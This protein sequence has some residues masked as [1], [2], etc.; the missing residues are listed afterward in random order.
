[1]RLWTKCDRCGKYIAVNLDRGVNNDVYKVSCND[2]ELA[3][4]CVTC[5]EYLSNWLKGRGE[6]GVI[7][8]E[9]D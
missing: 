5:R 9:D 2:V 3:T 7:K 8:V 6:Y 1:M 4:L